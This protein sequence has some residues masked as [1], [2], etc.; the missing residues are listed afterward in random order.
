MP[1]SFGP[2]S[3]AAA[4]AAMRSARASTF[5]TLAYVAAFFAAAGVGA[6]LLAFA[7]LA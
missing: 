7:A 2:S 3:P 4:R 1:K 5:W 6:E